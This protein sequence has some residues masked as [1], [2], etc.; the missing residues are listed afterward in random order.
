M[1]RNELLIEVREFIRQPYA[2]P[3]GYPKILL[4]D[5]GE[6]ICPACARKEYRQIS[7]ATR[8]Y[9]RDGWQAGAVGIHWEGSPLY[10]AQ[11]NAPTESAYGDPE[12]DSDDDNGSDP[13]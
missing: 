7:N 8:H 5:D 2:W 11:C 1:A 3:G 13:A 6:I 9:L 12:D 4:M 10:C